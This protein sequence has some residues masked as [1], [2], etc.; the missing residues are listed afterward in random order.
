MSLRLTSS[1]GL[2]LSWKIVVILLLLVNE[3]QGEILLCILI[4]LA[5]VKQVI[6][7]PITRS[8]PSHLVQCIMEDGM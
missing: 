3:C 8:L 6:E 4:L 1:E 2:G 5:R 7:N